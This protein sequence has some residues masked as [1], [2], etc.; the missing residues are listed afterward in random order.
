MS[1][2]AHPHAHRLGLPDFRLQ[3]IV[4]AA[5][6]HVLGYELCAGRESVPRLDATQWVR[7]YAR[8]PGELARLDAQDPALAAKP[9]FINLDS[10]QWLHPSI[11]RSV[12]A[13]ADARPVVLEW[14]ERAD[15]ARELEEASVQVQRWLA[16][17]QVAVDDVGE[18][19]DGLGRCLQVLPHFAKLS[20]NVLHAARSKGPR[21]LRH[22][23]SALAELGAQVIVEGVETAQDAQ[24]VRDSGAPYAQGFLYGRDLLS[25][26]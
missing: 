26:P 5:G 23:V 10:W 21:F 4:E 3:P 16:H 12:Q 25:V 18:G 13:C 17:G 1:S 22:V 24:L 8:L 11:L 7:W 2:H 14:T 6:G 19:Y 9:V 15:N 20:C